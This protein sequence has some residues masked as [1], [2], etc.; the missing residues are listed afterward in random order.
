MSERG[1]LGG[2]LT[3]AGFGSAAATAPPQRMS[4]RTRVPTAK[5]FNSEGVPRLP[6]LACSRSF[7]A[8]YQRC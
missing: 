8:V 5:A 2:E 6:V 7:D 1:S 4:K 3:L